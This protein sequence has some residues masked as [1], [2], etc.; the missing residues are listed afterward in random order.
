MENPVDMIASATPE[1]YTRTL[2]IVL[3]D[4]DVDMVMAINVTPLRSKTM[5]VLEAVHKARLTYPEK[6]VIAVMMATD[7]FYEAIKNR[8]EFPRGVP[9]PRT[10]E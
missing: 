4:P 7:D 2:E 3:A 1:K 10:R 6:P 5:A 9:F 8:P